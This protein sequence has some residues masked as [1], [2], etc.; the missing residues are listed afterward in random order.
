MQVH[1]LGI[2]ALSEL[3]GHAKS[4]S[5]AAV[6]ECKHLLCWLWAMREYG[7][8]FGGGGN[9]TTRPAGLRPSPARLQLA[10]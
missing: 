10:E 9:S 2:W 1:V 7:I 5:E 6:K 8:R 4:P 3:C